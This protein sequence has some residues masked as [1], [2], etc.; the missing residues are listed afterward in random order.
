MKRIKSAADLKLI[1]ERAGV[2]PDKE[3]VV[4]CQNLVR[5][6]H[7]YFTLRLLGYPKVRGYDGSWG[8]WG[9]RTDLPVE[10]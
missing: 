4:Y 2:T 7:T 8:E 5:S 10:K 3:V 9:N 1:Y 6:A